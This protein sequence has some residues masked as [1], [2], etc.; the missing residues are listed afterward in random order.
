MKI[1]TLFLQNKKKQLKATPVFGIWAVHV[2]IY[3]LYF[4]DLQ[5]EQMKEKFEHLY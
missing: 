4:L 2:F 1:K 5:N 3:L